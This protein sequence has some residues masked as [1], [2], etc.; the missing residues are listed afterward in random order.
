MEKSFK[1]FVLSLYKPVKFLAI[2]MIV[3]IVVSQ[4]LNLVKTIYNKRNNRPTKYGKL[5]NGR[6]I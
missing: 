6:L 4:I 2:V 5:P 1:K 3:S